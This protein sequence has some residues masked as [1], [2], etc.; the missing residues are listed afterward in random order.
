MRA[1][2]ACTKHIDFFYWV[3]L[4]TKDF[5]VSLLFR[6]Q[7]YELNILK[8]WRKVG[9]FRGPRSPLILTLMVQ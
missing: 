4:K 3:F 7:G 5:G 1:Y 2:Y 6:G 8:N 9:H